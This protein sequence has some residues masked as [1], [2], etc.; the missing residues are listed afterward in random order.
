MA[1]PIPF[2]AAEMLELAS[3]AVGKVDAWGPRGATLVSVEELEAMAAALVSFGLVATP[4][5]Q[6]S[7]AVIV[8]PRRHARKE[9]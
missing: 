1:D 9:T 7:P 3:R 8:V 6:K 4:P 5:G 2:E